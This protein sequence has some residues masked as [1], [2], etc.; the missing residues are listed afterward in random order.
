MMMCSTAAVIKAPE[1][2]TFVED[3]PEDEREAAT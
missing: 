2:I 1:E 3:L